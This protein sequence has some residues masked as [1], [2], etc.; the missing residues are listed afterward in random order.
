M[1]LVKKHVLVF[2]KS[3]YKLAKYQFVAMSLRK[4]S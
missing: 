3:I 1:I 4:D 2:K